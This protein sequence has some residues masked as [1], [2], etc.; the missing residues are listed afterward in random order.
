MCALFI[1]GI[2]HAFLCIHICWAPRE[3]LKPEPEW[4]RFHHLP[5]GPA[6]VNVPQK[7][8]WSLLLHK[9]SLSPL[10]LENASKSPFSCT[11]NGTERHVTCNILKMLLPGQRLMSSWRHEI[12]FVTVHM[13]EDDVSFCDRLGMLI[14]KTAK[15]CI[16]STW[17]TLL[18][19]RFVPVN[20]W[21]LIA[22]G[23]GFYAV[24]IVD[25]LF[26]IL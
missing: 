12:T 6:D 13:T 2:K 16:N 18:I 11:Y 3:V 19:H 15:L 22:C 25:F 10:N 4:R 20:T 21:L 9:N 5:R 1:I 14:R 7:H 24:S 17:I 8:V 23:T 26:F